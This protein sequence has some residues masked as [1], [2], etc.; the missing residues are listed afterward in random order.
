MFPKRS[1]SSMP[2]AA[3][4]YQLALPERV[5]HFGTRTVLEGPPWKLRRETACGSN[6]INTAVF[7]TYSLRV[8]LQ[9]QEI[10]ATGSVMRK[11]NT[12]FKFGF[13]LKHSTSH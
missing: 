11:T 4:N 7:E 13:S 6:I 5:A 1:S 12:Y 9:E 8:L 3:K 2:P 10:I